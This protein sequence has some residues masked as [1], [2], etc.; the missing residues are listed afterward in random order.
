M[1]NGQQS[2]LGELL[3][4][5][6]DLEYPSKRFKKGGK[7]VKGAF[8]NLVDVL[9][10]AYDDLQNIDRSIDVTIVSVSAIFIEFLKDEFNQFVFV[11]WKKS[12]DQ[13]LR[14]RRNKYEP[15][16]SP[17]LLYLELVWDRLYFSKRNH[18]Q[19]GRALTTVNDTT[20][21]LQ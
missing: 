7:I 18:K 2:V 21:T 15:I 13:A 19:F 3:S 11:S 4:S 6:H 20:T 1:K 10:L 5:A 8:E 9:R 16:G 12:I 14:P 17:F